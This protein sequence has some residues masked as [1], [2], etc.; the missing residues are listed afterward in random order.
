MMSSA[1]VA[2]VT[3]ANRGLGLAFVDRL[4][5]DG[6]VGTVVATCR[7]PERAAALQ[8]RRGAAQGRLELVALDVADESSVR[9][10]AETVA[11]R[12]PRLH[13]VL[14]VAGIL[15]AGE[16]VQ[17]EKKLDQVDPAALARVFAVNAFGP[18]LVAKHVQGL[19]IHPDRSVLANLSARVGSI[20]DDRLGGWYAYRASKAAQ[21]M[22]TRNLAIEL[23]RR[24]G[25]PIV[26]A[27]HPGTVETELSAPFRRNVPPEKLFSPDRAAR[28]LLEICD[29]LRP[30]ES[31]S[32]FAWDRQPIPW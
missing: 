1:R 31:G 28:Q 26:V 5:A 20:G 2:L 7:H 27:L 29:S 14:N 25:G 18:L 32:F 24:R 12:H 16:L 13:L 10:A 30:E 3:G 19:L 17:P 8:D 15:H 23:G 11:A 6:S 21:N 9:S 22:F 4:L